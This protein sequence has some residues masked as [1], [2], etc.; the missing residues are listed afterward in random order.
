MS[1]QYGVYRALQKS[2][3]FTTYQ[4]A[5]I[6]NKTKPR[7]SNKSIREA[8]TIPEQRSSHYSKSRSKFWS[9]SRLLGF[10]CIETGSLGL[11]D[12][13]HSKLKHF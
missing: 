9:G 10:E 13:K 11:N 2:P 1:A 5:S 3:V 6:T 8:S 7:E 4:V 12:P